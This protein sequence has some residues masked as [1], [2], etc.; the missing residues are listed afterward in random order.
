MYKINK[1]LCVVNK[2]NRVLLSKWFYSIDNSQQKTKSQV[3]QL[4]YLQKALNGK[5]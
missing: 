1:W 3:L 4:K 5:Q 2:N